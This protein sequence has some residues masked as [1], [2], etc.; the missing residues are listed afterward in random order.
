MDALFPFRLE[1][2][3]LTVMKVQGFRRP[4]GEHASPFD[5]LVR[6]SV[7]DLYPDAGGTP[8]I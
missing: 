2:L 4:A 6:R 5:G 1:P 7:D 3:D 8:P